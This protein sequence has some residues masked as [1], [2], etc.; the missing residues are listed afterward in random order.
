MEKDF[1]FTLQINVLRD[2]QIELATNELNN[3]IGQ[4][5]RTV[6]VNLSLN[7]YDEYLKRKP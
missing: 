2:G 1:T 3:Y 5:K 7:E 4:V 6:C